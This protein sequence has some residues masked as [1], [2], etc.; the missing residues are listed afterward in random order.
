MRV[1]HFGKASNERQHRTE[2]LKCDADSAD[3]IQLKSQCR[4]LITDE[5]CSW[6]MQIGCADASREM[7]GN[8]TEKSLAGEENNLRKLLTS[9][10]KNQ[11]RRI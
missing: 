6:V 8:E 10:R 4:S 3:S 11:K 9:S 5:V 7:Q 2:N 1:T